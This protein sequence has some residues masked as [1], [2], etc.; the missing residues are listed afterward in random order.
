MGYKRYSENTFTVD[1]SGATSGTLK[2]TSGKY[3]YFGIAKP[4]G[5]N[6]FRNLDQSDLDKGIQSDTSG[7]SATITYTSS[8]SNV[9]L[10]NYTLSQNT[11]GADRTIIFKYN[12]ID[13]FYILQK[14]SGDNLIYETGN[15]YV[16]VIPSISNSPDKIYLFVDLNNYRPTQA[17]LDSNNY[18]TMS[19][20]K[21]F[22]TTYS[23]S[24]LMLYFSNV[25]LPENKTI[26]E[27]KD[28]GILTVVRENS[29]F[30]SNSQYNKQI[31]YHMEK[32]NTLSALNGYY[33]FTDESKKSNAF[34]KEYSM[35]NAAGGVYG[36]IRF[37]IFN[38][39]Y[40]YGIY[41]LKTD[42]LV[43]VLYYAPVTTG[44]SPTIG[45]N[46][47]TKFIYNTNTTNFDDC[48]FYYDSNWYGY[49]YFCPNNLSLDL[50][51]KT[52][53]EMLNDGTLTFVE[54]YNQLTANEYLKTSKLKKWPTKIRAQNNTDIIFR[55]LKLTDNIYIYQYYMNTDNGTHRRS[56]DERVLN[57]SNIT[58][59]ADIGSVGVYKYNQQGNNSGN[60]TKH[61]TV[62]I[63]S[64]TIA[65]SYYLFDSSY[66]GTFTESSFHYKLAPSFFDDTNQD[67]TPKTHRY[68]YYYTTDNVVIS[69]TVSQNISKLSKVSGNGNLSFNIYSNCEFISMPKVNVKGSTTLKTISLNDYVYIYQSTGT[70]YTKKDTINFG[71]KN[72]INTLGQYT[73]TYTV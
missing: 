9:G 55:D 67:G 59:T 17:Q 27:L 11:S 18:K 14:Y 37:N 4:K 47:N 5:S 28:D 45:D 20:T 69:G 54:G 6:T 15:I 31:P 29:S 34:D 73:Y 21:G 42:T 24:G 13:L 19:G 48:K 3:I 7:C 33:D 63:V 30:T 32:V 70:T 38:S 23:G 16:C 36:S 61:A 58:T 53:Q 49:V 46:I 2:K 62:F 22:N 10:I 60:T 71:E 43:Y 51:T 8:K 72:N 50:T 35:Y 25:A 65:G 12:N 40:Y 57:F 66:S 1:N 56:T 52:C 39:H 64:F 68:V 44:K 26:K 41:K